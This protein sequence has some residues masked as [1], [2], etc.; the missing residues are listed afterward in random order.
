MR[1]YSY[2]NSIL[3]LRLSH[4]DMDL[5][6]QRRGASI[7]E[8]LYLNE[9]KIICIYKKYIAYNICMKLDAIRIIKSN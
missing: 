6:S 3:L 1:L 4:V 7:A 9:R 5:F 2:S 8:H